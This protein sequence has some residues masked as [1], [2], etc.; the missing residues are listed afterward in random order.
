MVLQ[1]GFCLDP[2]YLDSLVSQYHEQYINAKPFPHIVMDNFLPES[3]L[4]QILQ[5]F[6]HPEK[7]NWRKFDAPEEKKLASTSELQMGE[8]TRFLLYQLNSSIFLNFLEKLTGIDGIIPDPH[9]I[10]GGLHQIQK[11]GFLKVHVDFN[12]HNKMDLHR[13][14]NLLIYLNQDW[15]EEYGGHFELWDSDMTKCEKKVLPIFNRCVI[16][17]TSE[18]SY[19]GHP[20]P[21]TCPEGWTRKSLA[22]YYYSQ[23]R[24]EEE[25]FESHSTVFKTRPGE[26]FDKKNMT[27]KQVIKKFI[28]PIIFDLKKTLSKYN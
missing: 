3:V 1:Q 4:E 23:D 26:T 14:L 16:F 18:K 5:E 13:R 28:P 6:P 2:E 7:I 24:P 9:F 12:K 8:N 19:H 10:G 11:G 20:E 21:L 15:A 22:L 27:A 17:S 25:K